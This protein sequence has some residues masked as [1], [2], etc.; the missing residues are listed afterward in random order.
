MDSQK[1]TN[2]FWS[3][4]CSNATFVISSL[5]LPLP[6][7]FRE[8]CEFSELHSEF[9]HSQQ[10]ATEDVD[11][12]QVSCVSLLENQSVLVTADMGKES[13][14]DAYMELLILESYVQLMCGN[15]IVKINCLE[16]DGFTISSILVWLKRILCQGVYC[17]I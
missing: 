14:K 2:Y 9:N 1:K 10:E 15:Y 17:I 7:S 16:D 8:D 6:L 13:H 3:F 12:D 4:V 11:Q 5:S